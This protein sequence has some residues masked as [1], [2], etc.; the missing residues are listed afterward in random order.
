MNASLTFIVAEPAL[1]ASNAIIVRMSILHPEEVRQCKVCSFTWRAEQYDRKDRNQGLVGLGITKRA[2]D[3]HRQS[4]YERRDRLIDVYRKCSSCGSTKVRTLRGK[5][6]KEATMR[7]ATKESDDA[8][9]LEEPGRALPTSPPP[10]FYRKGDAA[11][12]EWWDGSQWTG[13]RRPD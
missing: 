12:D 5:K 9:P 6:A 7:A 1:R 2:A 10:G 13:I 3:L 8:H 11:E 4:V